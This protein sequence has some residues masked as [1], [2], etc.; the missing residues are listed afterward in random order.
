[1][2][3]SPRVFVETSCRYS[4]NDI[5]TTSSAGWQGPR[6]L[7]HACW[8]Q[9]PKHQ[10]R[11]CGC[12]YFFACFCPVLRPN[13]QHLAA[14]LASFS[15]AKGKRRRRAMLIECY[16]F[17]PLPRPRLTHVPP[18]P[19][20]QRSALGLLGLLK[21]ASEGDAR[22]Y[23]LRVS[24]DSMGSGAAARGAGVQ[25]QYL[26]P[27]LRRMEVRFGLPSRNWLLRVSGFTRPNMCIAERFA[28]NVLSS[29]R[30]FFRGAGVFPLAS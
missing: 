28:L 7:V 25:G 19:P 12:F 15:L 16:E 13:I 30:C 1:M 27:S 20:F 26:P 8:Q 22:L 24:T 14:V 29:S 23:T 4:A 11:M 10:N 9:A 21:A 17:L 18:P 6:P 2:T 5:S 3:Y